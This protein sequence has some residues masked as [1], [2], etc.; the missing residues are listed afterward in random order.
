R[1]EGR[2]LRM[3]LSQLG[4]LSRPTL[5]RLLA[6]RG[7][8]FACLAE[9]EALVQPKLQE[10]RALVRSGC[11]DALPAAAGGVDRAADLTCVG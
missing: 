9:F 1:V 5:D 6:A 3:G 10:L 8:G 7:K 4:E 2:S 11:L